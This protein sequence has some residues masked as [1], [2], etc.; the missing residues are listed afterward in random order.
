M[1]HVRRHCSTLHWLLERSMGSGNSNAHPLSVMYCNCGDIELR[2]MAPLPSQP[3]YFST[4]VTPQADRFRPQ[5]CQHGA[6]LT[7]TSLGVEVD[8][9]GN[10]G[11]GGPDVPHPWRTLPPVRPPPSKSR[12]APHG[13]LEALGYRMRRKA[14]L[15]PITMDSG[16]FEN[17]HL[18]T[19][20]LG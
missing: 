6:A 16:A 18:D 17:P 3:S 20:P 7:Y 8:N 14:T 13:P 15:D 9:G 1:N 4:A 5:I 12:P 10:E 19:P 11:G 2:P